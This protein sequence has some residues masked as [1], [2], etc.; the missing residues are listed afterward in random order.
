MPTPRGMAMWDV[1]GEQVLWKK[2]QPSGYESE[3]LCFSPDGKTLAVAN[4]P[5]GQASSLA[6]PSLTILDVASGR[7]IATLIE[8][9]NQRQNVFRCRQRTTNHRLVG[10]SLEIQRRI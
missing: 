5:N 1:D 2:R 3:P 8:R 10:A 7:Q 6:L 9:Q 4:N